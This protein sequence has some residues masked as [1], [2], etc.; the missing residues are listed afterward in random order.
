MLSWRCFETLPHQILAEVAANYVAAHRKRKAGLLVPPFA[1]IEHLVKA[2]LIVE[3]LSFVDQK[4]GVNVAFLDHVDDLVERDDHILKIR[5]VD[6]HCQKR[7]GQ[8]ARD[9]DLH[10]RNIAGVARLL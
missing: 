10:R 9:R 2:E 1:E 3:E 8:F 5:I 7:A 6:P 4:P